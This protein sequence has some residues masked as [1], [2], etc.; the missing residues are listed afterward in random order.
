MQLVDVM[1]P[2]WSRGS[3]VTWRPAGRLV[4]LLTSLLMGFR[5]ER[6]TAQRFISSSQGLLPFL[7]GAPAFGTSGVAGRW[8]RYIQNHLGCLGFENR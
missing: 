5:G 4:E 8:D 6:G 1:C 2:E 7:F 3:S